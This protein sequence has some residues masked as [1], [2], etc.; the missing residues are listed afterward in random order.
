MTRSLHWLEH[1]AA[2][3]HSGAINALGWHSLEIKHNYTEAAR[4]FERAHQ[5]GNKDAA[6]NLGHMYYYA[7]NA[8]RIVD[9]VRLH[10]ILPT[11]TP[12]FPGGFL[13]FFY[14]WKHKWTIYRG[15]TKSSQLYPNCVSN[16]RIIDSVS[17]VRGGPE[18]KVPLYSGS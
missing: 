10:F 11:V 14:Q 17:P 6:H 13:P 16:T 18:K 7:R 9:R 1:A 5:L 12:A 4:R 8:D 2:L 3:N 15:V